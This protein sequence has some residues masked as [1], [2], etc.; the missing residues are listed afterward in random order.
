MR[1]IKIIIKGLLIL[2]T[3][4]TSSGCLMCAH[5]IHTLWC[6]WHWIGAKW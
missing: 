1:V 6:Y 4:T 5:K 2:T 3:I